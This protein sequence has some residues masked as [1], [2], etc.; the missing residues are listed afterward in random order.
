MKEV[1]VNINRSKYIK[2]RVSQLSNDLCGLV[3][4]DIIAVPSLYDNVEMYL[5]HETPKP[6]KTRT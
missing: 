4:R 2:A 6:K 3:R 5:F 1:N